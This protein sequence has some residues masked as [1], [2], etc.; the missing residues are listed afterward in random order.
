MSAGIEPRSANLT[1]WSHIKIGS[2]CEHFY[3]P[4]NS[5]Q[6]TEIW[7]KCQK[8]NTQPIFLAGG[9]N[10][11]F[12]N[13]KGLY[14]ISD[15]NLPA[16]FRQR[17]NFITVSGNYNINRLIMKAANLD[18]GGLEFLAGIPAHISGLAKM[19]AGAFG[20]EFSQF[21]DSINVLQANGNTRIVPASELN[22]GYRTSSIEDYILSLTLKLEN[23]PKKIIHSRIKSNIARR[24]FSQPLTLPNLG[25][26]FK[27]PPD[28]SAGRLLEKAGFKGKRLNNIA[29][30]DK[31]A[32]FL[33][34]PGKAS[35]N[36][37]MELIL[38]AQESVKKKFNIDLELEIKVIE[39]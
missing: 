1:S 36:E 13:S 30:S 2:V 11:L 9:S 39:Q 17:D 25:S 3:L 27:N 23:L 19:N 29:F 38:A 28:D 12:G 15:A 26:V 18:L 20:S 34:N 21:I 6:I 14:I 31:H 7:Q 35:F 10:L 4:S 24:K 37:A 32:N 16:W 22:F 5:E 8:M 33:V